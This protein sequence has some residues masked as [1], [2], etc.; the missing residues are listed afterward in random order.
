MRFDRKKFFDGVKDRIDPTLNQSQVDGFEFLLTSFENTARWSDARLIA[1]ALATIWHETA[2][3]MQPINEY[4]GNAYFNKRYGPKTKAGK[5]LGN[6]EAGDGARFHGRGYVQLTGR[7]NYAKYG[8]EDN[9]DAVLEPANAFNI[10]TDGMFNGTFTG[11][12]F[13][14]YIRG[15]KCD[16]VNARRII[17]G[18]DK[19][20]VIAGYAK[21]FEKA[22]NSA[23][24]PAGENRGSLTEDESI[25]AAKPPIEAQMPVS[26][27][28]TPTDV[29]EVEQVAAAPAEADV[30]SRL[31]SRIM[32]IPAAVLTA[33]GAAVT[34][35]TDAP[36]NLV[37]TLLAVGALVFVIYLI[38]NS[39]RNA[40]KEK[41]DTE[42][43]KIREQQAFELQ[44]ITLMSAAN[45]DQNAV[46]IVPT[47][48]PPTEIANSD[49]QAV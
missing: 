3:T 33:I 9:P 13:S 26:L 35:A 14:D 7:N 41:R 17:N 42:L 23:A 34:W 45:K 47:P 40:G 5:A 24:V 44:K 29:I 19:A 15:N 49:E 46:R 36:L 16:Y 22:L 21:S 27:T 43:K 31:S 11:K 10:L 32:A 39:I 6:T 30:I 1:Y 4:G 2:Y 20:G 12:G 37:I 38:I 8:F 48:P 28:A 18:V 25:S